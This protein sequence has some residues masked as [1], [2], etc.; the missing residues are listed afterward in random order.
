MVWM[1]RLTY[2]LRVSIYDAFRGGLQ[3]AIFLCWLWDLL[4]GG[5]SFVV[6]GFWAH[7]GPVPVPLYLP[8]P[9]H[10]GSPP[11]PLNFLSLRA[12]CWEFCALL[13]S[14]PGSSLHF[15]PETSA[16]P[17]FSRMGS[18]AFLLSF[19]IWLFLLSWHPP[20]HSAIFSDIVAFLARRWA[21][22]LAGP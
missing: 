20:P 22:W 4:G 11:P 15:L 17:S 7:K 9:V 2:I 19:T 13:P 18:D 21:P 5:G 8:S 16:G 10:C 6:S 1:C 3:P 12:L 14:L